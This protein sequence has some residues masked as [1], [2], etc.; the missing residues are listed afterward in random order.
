MVRGVMT[1]VQVN[2]GRCPIV[3]EPRRWALASVGV[4][5]VCFAG[6]GVFVPGLPTTIFLILASW[7]LTR[8]CPWLEERVRRVAIFRPF[9][10]VIDQGQG[11]PT[12]AKVISLVLMWIAIGSS[13]WLMMERGV[14]A[15][16]WGT[17]IVAGLV[18]TI[19]IVRS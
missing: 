2:E 9:F 7:C 10:R 1:Q 11:M 13:T 4:V 12:R 14:H 3:R 16:W 6:V 8:S 18:G 19:A 17:V 5:C 15:G